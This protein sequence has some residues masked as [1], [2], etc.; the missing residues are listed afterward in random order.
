M[1]NEKEKQK[2]ILADYKRSLNNGENAMS[3]FK[4][5]QPSHNTMKITTKVIIT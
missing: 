2:F 5:I 3:K 4:I 1:K